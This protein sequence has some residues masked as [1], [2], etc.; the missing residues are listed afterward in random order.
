[1]FEKLPIF[2]AF[3]GDEQDGLL[4][5]SLVECP[6]TEIEWQAFS[7]AKKEVK[8]SVDEDKHL[9]RGVVML[10]DTPIYRRNGDYEYYI[11]YSKATLE[12][13]AQKMLS[14]HTFNTLDTEHSHNMLGNGDAELRELFIKDIQ[15]GINPSGFENVPDGSLL[16]TYHI[17]NEDIWQRVRNGEFKGFSL[18][19]V[20][21]VKEAETY[22]NQNRNKSKM[23]K[24]AKIKE[25]LQELLV[26]FSTIRTKEGIE[27]EVG[28]E[29]LAEGVAVKAEDGTYELED[30][31][32]IEVKEGVIVSIAEPQPKEEEVIEEPA[33]EEPKEEV[34]EE[35]K[36]EEPKEEKPEE[37][38]EEEPKEEVE[39]EQPAEEVIEE[40]KEEEKPEEIV[41]EIV[42][43]IEEPQEADPMEERISELER[44]LADILAILK[45]P[46][47]EGIVDEFFSSEKEEEKHSKEYSYNKWG[48]RK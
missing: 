6:A 27:I 45:K 7:E 48:L 18:E 46:V 10:A 32:T 44:K 35:P 28:S 40:P 33:E 34:V 11:K 37:V 36:E 1:M 19:G 15:N 47:D 17:D 22:N 30:G 26:E 13:M 3:I 2:E 38:I 16:C 31:R 41:E 14:D 9:L 5:M 42:D 8:F 24:I 21:S 20:F 39:E 43:V 29:E 4:I 23:S 25:L 12:Q